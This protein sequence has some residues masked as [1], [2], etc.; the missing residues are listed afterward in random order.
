M[1]AVTTIKRLMELGRKYRV[2][3]EEDFIVAVKSFVEEAK[4]I[5]RMRKQLAEDGVTVTKAYVKG[6]ENVTAH[7]MIQE[8][9]KHVDCANRILQTMNGIIETRGQRVE[10]ERD[11]LDDFRIRA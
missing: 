6:R 3:E 9:P 10:Q 5:D 1:A 8:I 4:L 7:P 11:E 2:D